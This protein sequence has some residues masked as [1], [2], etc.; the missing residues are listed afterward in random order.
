[1]SD[2]CYRPFSRRSRHVGLMGPAHAASGAGISLLALGLLHAHPEYLSSF[3]ELSLPIVALMAGIVLACSGAVMVPDLDNTK[4]RVISALGVTGTVM[5]KV[6]R[7]TSVMVQSVVR[8]K[9]DDATP[10]PHRGFWHSTVGA[11]TAGAIVFGLCQIPYAVEVL[12]HHVSVG[13]ALAFVI[14][15]ML[16]NIANASLPNSP[17]SAV[18]KHAAKFEV[19][20][21]LVSIVMAALVFAFI[22]AGNYWWL[23]VSVTFGMF[24]H[25]LGDMLTTQGVPVFFPIVSLWRGRMWWKT[26]LTSIEASSKALNNTVTVLS[27]AAG[28]AGVVLLIL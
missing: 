2:A 22:P 6:F 21:L 9:Y 4:A 5:S 20:S 26:R 24:I 16:V 3:A 17:Q 14:F 27:T 7:S 10:N 1:M 12:G 11:I 28:V 13:S 19:L 18:L 25:I 8:T 15:V 23:A